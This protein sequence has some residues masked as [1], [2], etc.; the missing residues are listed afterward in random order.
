MTLSNFRGRELLLAVAAALLVAGCETSGGGGDG[1]TADRATCTA[2][3][4]QLSKLDAE[5]VPALVEAQ[6][7]GKKLP[8]AQK[9][10]A[11]AYNQ[12]L[13]DYLGARCHVQ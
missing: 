7:R 11:D 6:S 4:A 12:L 2:K 3:K 9:A 10:K 8:P 1:P 13:N 5:G